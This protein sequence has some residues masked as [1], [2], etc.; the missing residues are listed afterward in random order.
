MF[1]QTFI[2]QIKE[3]HC[4]EWKDMG[5]ISKFNSIEEAQKQLDN[6]I[7]YYNNKN[8]FR[9]QKVTCS[10]E[11]LIEKTGISNLLTN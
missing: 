7:K 9:I 10:D 2:L 11:I 5:I 8:S 6:T 3:E 1:L 4:E